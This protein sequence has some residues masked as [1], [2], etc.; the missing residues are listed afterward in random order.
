MKCLLDTSVVGEIF[1]GR[2]TTPAVRKA[3]AYRAL[4][5]RFTLSVLTRYEVTR[6]LKDLGHLPRLQQF[7]AEWGRH[8]ILPLTDDVMS[9]AGDVWVFLKKSGQLIGDVDILIGA[10]ALRHGLAVAT[11]NV[12]HF[13]RIPGL[14]VED[15][16][17]P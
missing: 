13:R 15:W 16:S 5:G 7:E 10:T 8:D 1:L 6:G 14:T 3:Q 17:R 4:N 9:V 2:R 11:R 12:R